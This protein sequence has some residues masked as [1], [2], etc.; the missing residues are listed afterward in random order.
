[1]ARE[2]TELSTTRKTQVNTL[3]NYTRWPIAVL[4]HCGWTTEAVAAY[5]DG[6]KY[7]SWA[8]TD[9]GRG[10]A[11]APLLDDRPPTKRCRA[12]SKRGKSGRERGCTLR[13]A[14]TVGI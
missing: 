12:T 4:R 2:L 1:M 9:A 6:T 7:Q 10:I 11:E 8:L 14:R 13:H 5:A 3:R